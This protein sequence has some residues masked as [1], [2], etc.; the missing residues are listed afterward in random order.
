M[1]KGRWGGKDANDESAENKPEND[2]GD[3]GTKPSGEGSS[4]ASDEGESTNEDEETPA[5]E[6]SSDFGNFGVF[7]EP[8]SKE[9]SPDEKGKGKDADADLENFFA[10]EERERAASEAKELEEKKRA[11]SKAAERNAR[12]KEMGDELDL[13]DL[14]SDRLYVMFYGRPETGKSVILS[15]LLYFLQTDPFITWNLDKASMDLSSQR[16]LAELRGSIREGVFVERTANLDV[17]EKV[18]ELKGEL[19]P[20]N[21]KLPAL[22]IC[23]LELAGED[24]RSIMVGDSEKFSGELDPRIRHYLE[25][26]TKPDNMCFLMVAPCNSASKNEDALLDMFSYMDT[27][28]MGIAP[29]IVMLSMWDLLGEGGNR[30][31]ELRRILADDMPMAWQQIQSENRD[32]ATMRFT[33]GASD[34]G[35][36]FSYSSKD[37][38]ALSRRLYQIGTGRQRDP[39]TNDAPGFWRRFFG[40]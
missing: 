23:F 19:V 11:D 9:E 6:Q 5:K 36:D 18:W 26:W 34:N 14:E 21:K 12:F 33:I 39:W 17:G 37:S 7:D 2:G 28:N 30:P 24:L 15:G 35:S 20:K 27:K 31:G 25:S 40:K 3:S 10:R 4:A 13:P 22:K 8:S 32:V 16:K 1:A 38:K 29:S